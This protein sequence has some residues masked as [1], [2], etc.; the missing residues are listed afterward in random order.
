MQ[1]LK[2]SPAPKRPTP[3]QVYLE[4]K[5]KSVNLNLG[6]H[7]LH[8]LENTEM[9]MTINTTPLSGSVHD[10]ETMIE[11]IPTMEDQEAQC[12]VAARV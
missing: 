10:D 7:R 11:I 12:E 2:T 5:K 8:C 3:P 6:Q 9:M 4:E 1:E